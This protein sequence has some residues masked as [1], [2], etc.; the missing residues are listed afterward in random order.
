MR[1]NSFSQHNI[2]E[3]NIDTNGG[4]ALTEQESAV[5]QDDDLEVLDG[6]D[7]NIER[8]NQSQN[9]DSHNRTVTGFG[10]QDREESSDGQD[11]SDKKRRSLA[12]PAGDMELQ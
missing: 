8:T 6:A 11:D 3:T 2:I 10:D 9:I 5:Q 7:N 4:L 1:K 12:D